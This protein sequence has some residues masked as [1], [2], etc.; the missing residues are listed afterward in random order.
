MTRKSTP[1][2]RRTARPARMGKSLKSDGITI[3]KVL[4][5]RL[6]E[7]EVQRIIGACKAALQALREVRATYHDWAAL[8][9]ARHV[10]IAI[11]DGGI[12]RGQRFLF[13]LGEAAL[14]N[15]GDRCGD[16]EE[17]WTPRP[18]AGPE[19]TALADMIAAHSRQVRELTY[20]EYIR[21]ADLA[22]SRVETLGG[23]VYRSAPNAA[24]A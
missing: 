5:T 20:S 15:I 17:A 19:L 1:Y 4:N 14:D 23:K 11:E 6:S 24:T 7:R 3:T 12:V 2:G 13:E 18:C 22:V 8:C 10:G 9:T 16:T 21:A